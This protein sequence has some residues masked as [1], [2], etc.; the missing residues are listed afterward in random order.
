MS[1]SLE[2]S[3]RTLNKELNMVSQFIPH[4]G[5]PHVV[6]HDP[7]K[8]PSHYTAGKVE[9]IDAIEAA[10]SGLDGHEA[11]HVGQ[12]IKYVWRWK[13]KGGVEDLKKALWYLERL[14]ANLEVE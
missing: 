14:I 3:K 4:S 11:F 9:C 12:V 7:V 1:P 8:S 13:R 5:S 6:E 2:F 10:S